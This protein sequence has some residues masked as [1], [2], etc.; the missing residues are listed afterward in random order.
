LID[1]VLLAGLRCPLSGL[2]YVRNVFAESLNST[3]KALIAVTLN[4]SDYR[5]RASLGHLFAE[6]SACNQNE[7]AF[8]GFA[9][10]AAVTNSKSSTPGSWVLIESIPR[11]QPPSGEVLLKVLAHSFSVSVQPA[12]LDAKKSVSSSVHKKQADSW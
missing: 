4:G 9:M 10:R 11:A 5:I 8:E 6:D 12:P 2:F 3:T 7:L 1:A